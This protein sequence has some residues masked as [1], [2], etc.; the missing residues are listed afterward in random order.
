VASFTALA[1][2]TSSFS[3]LAYD[4]DAGVTPPRVVSLP[5]WRGA[6]TERRIP[7][8]KAVTKIIRQLAKKQVKRLKDE[9]REFAYEQQLMTA[10]AKADLQ[11]R[12]V[13]GELLQRERERLIE[14]EV[15]RLKRKQQMRD[16]E[17]D[18]LAF[19]MSVL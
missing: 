16:E 6:S 15:V 11:Y 2:S 18:V 9:E 7:R 3:P 5:W 8:P 17:E 1:F 12:E 4:F 19:L 13:Y 14:A 10:L